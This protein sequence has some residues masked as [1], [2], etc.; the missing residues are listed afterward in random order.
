MLYFEKLFN[1]GPG[2]SRLEPRKRV[3][4]ERGLGG[5]KYALVTMGGK[6]NLCFRHGSNPDLSVIF[7]TD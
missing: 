4:L 1:F 5:A 6:K 3:P 7:A 2:L